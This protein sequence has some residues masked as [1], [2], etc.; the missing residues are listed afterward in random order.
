MKQKS[1]FVIV[2]L[3]FFS[4]V[5][6]INKHLENSYKIE[7]TMTKLYSVEEIYFESNTMK[8]NNY[9]D[10]EYVVTGYVIDEPTAK[11][12]LGKVSFTIVDDLMNPKQRLI[13]FS[14]LSKKD[15]CKYD[16][17]KVKAYLRSFNSQTIV[18]T[19]KNITDEQ[20]SVCNVE[21]L[22]NNYNNKMLKL[23]TTNTGSLTVL[24]VATYLEGKKE[25][26][27]ISDEFIEKYQQNGGG[28]I[29]LAES[30]G[31]IVNRQQHLPNQ[32]WHFFESWL[33][34]CIANNTISWEDDAR[35]NIYTRLL[36]P[37]LLLWI[38]E[39]CG[40]EPLKVKN[41]MDVA[42]KAKVDGTHIS[43]MAKNMRSCVPWED[44]IAKL[45][46]EKVATSVSL[47]LNN[48]ELNVGE[49]A[50][51]IATVT[52]IDATDKPTWLVTEGNECVS[53]TTSANQIKI[54]AIKEGAATI[55]VSYNVNVFS[56]CKIIITDTSDP[57]I[58]NLPNMIDLD[59][60]GEYELNPKLNK[61]N[62][63]FSFEVENDYITVNEAGVIKGLKYGRSSITIICNENQTIY[64]T[65]E[66]EVFNHGNSENP[67]SVSET[68]N[69][70]EKICQT[71]DEYSCQKVIIKGKVKTNSIDNKLILLDLNDQLVEIEIE[72]FT[73]INNVAYPSQ[74]DE[75]I[76]SGYLYNDQDK[77]RL[78]SKEDDKVEIL[79]NERG[80]SKIIFNQYENAIVKIDGIEDN[81]SKNIKN[82]ELFRFTIDPNHGYKIKN[83]FI[84][85]TQLETIN[86][87]YCFEVMGDTIITINIVDENISD[88]YKYNISYDLGT[89]VTAKLIDTTEILFN[90]FILDG[91]GVGIINS[92]TQM[93]YIYGGANGGRGDT[94][95]Y[96]GDILKFG[97]TSV[98]GSLTFDLKHEIN[99]VK[100]T[101]Y[102]YDN[103]CIIQIGDSNSNDWAEQ[104]SDNQTTKF[105]CSEMNE[106]SK[107]IV[108]SD[109]TTS[110]LINFESTNSLKIATTNKKPLFITSIEFGFDESYN[111]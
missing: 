53:V 42:V 72:D 8:L 90:T 98:N 20:K 14:V 3:C 33:G 5:F 52:P 102:V 50:T 12:D 108:E 24:D 13:V 91:D 68:L 93:E 26:Y 103:N 66:V 44:I 77:L 76:I 58:V 71:S 45:K 106:V 69:L 109:M 11:N 56:E 10:C 74:N 83:V 81:S 18:M 17:V 41:A 6:F 57:I 96:T 2:V 43:T 92:I 89:R 80:T 64:K 63:T 67:L 30:L 110:I 111:K 38:F 4:I 95:W 16:K 23:S 79:N 59:I 34:E 97:T 87:E 88:S 84:N 82:G 86:N 37:E 51:V 85:Q 29:E 47:N 54:K 27:P 46:T 35:K 60:N 31:M 48:I 105:T 36:C 104:T 49:E 65:I 99:Y 101:G 22:D 70:L 21:I 55:K 15:V 61:G 40:V 19:G 107:E 78:T 62:G 32:K 25:H 39:A 100:I 73:M 94:A 7:K 75:V 1:L 9:S 28:Y